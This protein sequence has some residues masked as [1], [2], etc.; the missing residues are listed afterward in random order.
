MTHYYLLG[1]IVVMSLGASFLFSGFEAGI[2]A[3]NRLRIRQLMRQGNPKA[4]RLLGYLEQPEN[5]LWTILVGNTLANFAAVGLSLAGLHLC[6][7]NHPVWFW[8]AFFAVVFLL[9]AVGDLLPKTLFQTFPNRLCLLMAAPYRFVHITL[10]P[11]V[12]SMNWFSQ[13]L[14]HVTGGKTY[15]G[16][17]F[18]SREELQWL[19]QE[20]AQD[21]SSEERLMINRV[22]DFQK[23]VLRQIMVPLDRVVAI[24]S[25]TSMAAVLDICRDRGLTRLLVEQNVGGRRRILGLVSLKNTLYSPHLDPAKPVEQFIKPALF[26]PEDLLLEKALQRMQRSG[27]RLAVVLGRN[28]QELGVVSLQDILKAIFGEVSL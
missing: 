28:R 27:Q 12:R 3:L 8:I 11:V 2:F 23:L 5:F 10:A 19:M 6:L 15:T 25:Q 9:F 24:T 14:L 17:L 26:L 16:R 7:E 18:G 4:R 13:R 1:F 21:L 20:T 22:L